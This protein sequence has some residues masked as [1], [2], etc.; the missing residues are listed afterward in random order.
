VIM[1]AADVRIDPGFDKALVPI[2]AFLMTVVGLVLVVA[3]SNLAGLLLIRASSRQKEMAVRLALGASRARLMSLLLTE[4]ALLGLLGGAVG[5]LIAFWTASAILSY[6]PPFPV[7]ISVNFQLDEN[8]LAFNLLLSIATGILFGLAPALK[9][10]RCDLVGTIK[11]EVPALDMGRKR[12]TLRNFFVVAQVA[13][14][15]VLLVGAGIC[16]R[17]L[18]N[19]QNVDIG[20]E[21]ESSALAVVDVGRAGYDTEEKGRAFFERYREVLASSPNIE[22][23]AVTSRVPFGLWGMDKIPIQRPDAEPDPD[24]DRPEVDYTLVTPEYFDALG[25]PILRGRNFN[26]QDTL[27]SPKVVIVSEAMA[28]EYWDSADAI[29]KTLIVGSADD[30]TRVQVVGVTGDALVRSVRSPLREPEPFIYL[31]FSQRYAPVAVLIATTS[32]DPATLPEVFRRELHALDYRVPLF[33]SKTMKEHLSIML[34]LPR[35]TVL[36]FSSFGILAMVLASIGLYGLVAFSVSQRTREVGIRMA[37]GAPAARVIKMVL[38]EGMVL[39]TVGVGVGL[40]FA[41]LIT[42]PMA[43]L[44]MGVSPFDPVT[45][46]S[47]ALLLLS[48]SALAAY[49]PARRIAKADPMTALRHE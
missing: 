19:W 33:E 25:V 10:S 13:V 16:I 8:V 7:S 28:R 11:D 35:L 49:I 26:A 43:G 48:V 32:G 24:A 47:V 21:S 17:N 4:S 2:S 39:V 38:K 31:P 42:R 36:L 5:L 41:S 37:L 45:F 9:A 40:V 29:G 34:Y 18:S 23:V 30:T 27:G 6:Q 12:F 44:L 3:C 1:A 46:V 22:T 15:L 20:F 14:S